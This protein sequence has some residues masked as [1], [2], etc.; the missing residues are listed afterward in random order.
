VGYKLIANGNKNQVEPISFF[1]LTSIMPQHDKAASLPR[2][3]FFAWGVKHNVMDKKQK[4][5][6]ETPIIDGDARPDMPIGVEKGRNTKGKK[7]SGQDKFETE[8][9]SDINSMED[10]KDAKS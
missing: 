1:T 9:V 8:R 7:K 10:Y 3:N 5:K 2:H 4:E 6:R